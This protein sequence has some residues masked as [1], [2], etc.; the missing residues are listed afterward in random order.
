MPQIFTANLVEDNTPYH[1]LPG[2]FDFNN[3]SGRSNMYQRFT[4]L[5]INLDRPIVR[6]LAHIQGYNA[7]LTGDYFIEAFICANGAG[8]RYYPPAGPF[9]VWVPL[10][11]QDIANISLA[12]YPLLA[13]CL[14]APYNPLST[15]TSS[16]YYLYAEGEVPAVIGLAAARSASFFLATFGDEDM[17]CRK[18][19]LKDYAQYTTQTGEKIWAYQLVTNYCAD[20]LELSVGSF[21]DPAAAAGAHVLNAN[22]G[23]RVY[24]AVVGANGKWQANNSGLPIGNGIPFVFPAWQ[25]PVLIPWMG[26]NVNVVVELYTADTIAAG[27]TLELSIAPIQEGA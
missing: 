13:G 18:A 11:A 16:V 9:D 7:G 26:K 10:D 15:I 4:P 12:T 19:L 24:E 8:A 22:F 25:S 2:H 21:I 3:G 14:D 5:T 27:T 1:S 6:G 17:Y 20:W 23:V